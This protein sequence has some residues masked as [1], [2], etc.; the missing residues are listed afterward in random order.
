MQIVGWEIR[1][2]S[3]LNPIL[4]TADHTFFWVIEYKES[5]HPKDGCDTFLRNVCYNK[6]TQRHISEDDI[7]QRVL[8][9]KQLNL[10]TLRDITFTLTAFNLI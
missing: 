10:L 4:A 9:V 7:L 8:S 5:F 2:H 3:A 1:N 6:I